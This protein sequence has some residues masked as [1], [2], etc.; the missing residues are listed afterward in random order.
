MKRK[1]ALLLAALLLLTTG[2]GTAPAEEETETSVT[3]ET[4]G[5]TEETLGNTMTGEELMKELKIG[6]NLGNT[7]D[8]PD[9]ETSWGNPFTTPE[10]LQYVKE[11]GFN[12][13]RIPITWHTH[14]G[15]APEYIIDEAWMNR[16][17][18]VVNQALDAGLYVIINSHHDNEVYMPNA[19]NAESARTYLTAIWAQIAEHFKDADYHLIFQTMNEPRVE[20]ASYEWWVD[21]GNADCMAAV[22]VVNQLN[23]AAVDTIRATGGNNADRFIIVSPYAANSNAARL[24]SF[25]LPE[26]P[27]GKLI[28]SIHAYTPYDLCLNTDTTKNTFSQAGVSEIKSMMAGLSRMYVR[29]GIPVIIDEMGIVN[30]DNPEAKYEWAKT[31]VSLATEYGMPCVWW[32]NGVTTVGIESF[33]IVNRRKLSINDA[34]QSVYDG[35]ME[36]L[37]G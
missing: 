6:W 3:T 19:E 24:S 37:E 5:A 26:D 17:D 21:T 10:L 2:C 29:K 22:E 1:L 8:A 36:G 11:L 30:K 27:A 34:F 32:D 12:T 23:Q 33:A 28:V 7:F 9:G 4:T 18:T 13:I 35:L 14:V 16:I 20:G 31:Y 15:E 25:R